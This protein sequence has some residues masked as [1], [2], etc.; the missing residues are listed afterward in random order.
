MFATDSRRADAMKRATFA[1]WGLLLAVAIAGSAE[2]AKP[3]TAIL[4]V[5]RAELPDPNF[6]DSVVLV[7][8]NIAHAPV[9]VIV[10]RPTSMT[11]SRL[12]PDIERLRRH[13]E[14]V[15]FGG[16]VDLGS[17]SFLFR[18]DAP[19][20]HAVA[21]VEGICFSRSAE[22]LR[23]LLERDKPADGLRIFIGLS[24]WAPGQLEAEISRGDWTLEAAKPGTLFDRRPE[25]PWPERHAPDK[26]RRS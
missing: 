10:N 25:H 18:A 20:E 24:G 21:A 7:M 19:P 9:G 3:P 16:P 26:S 23:T 5:A 22:L 11:A 14:K 1:L 4:L 2:E 12:F 6:R 15:Y 13:D 8:N 17:V